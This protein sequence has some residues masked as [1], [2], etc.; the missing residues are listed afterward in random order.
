MEKIRSSYNL[1]YLLTIS[2]PTTRHRQ[3]VKEM[4]MHR[5]SFLSNI[6]EGE[7]MWCLK[8]R[9]I[10]SRGSVKTPCQWRLGVNKSNFVVVGCYL[11]TIIMLSWNNNNVILD[12]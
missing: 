7:V 11:G 12:L 6:N 8:T 2:L 4:G 10:V 5:F 9:L 3:I 1:T